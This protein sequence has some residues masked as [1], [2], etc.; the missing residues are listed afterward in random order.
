MA[1]STVCGIQAEVDYVLINRMRARVGEYFV[2]QSSG[3][4]SGLRCSSL[5]YEHVAVS[6]V[7][8]IQAE[9]DHASLCQ[10]FN[11]RKVFFSEE[12]TLMAFGKTWQDLNGVLYVYGF[13]GLDG[14]EGD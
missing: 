7:R 13:Q 10:A 5:R 11:S 6:T 9:V 1:V 12:F 4:G 14:G 2:R 3:S 8:G